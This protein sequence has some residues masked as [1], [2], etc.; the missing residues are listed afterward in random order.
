[1]KVAIVSVFPPYRGGIARFNRHLY[2]TLLAEQHQVLAINFKR[3]YPGFIFPGKTQFTDESPD[4]DIEPIMDTLSMRSWWRTAARLNDSDVETVIIPFWTS[5]L[6]VAKIGLIKKLN[7]KR[8]I[9]LV[10]N[11]VPHDAK[12]WQKLL[13]RRFFN[14]CDAYI[15]LSGSVTHDLL[16]LCPRVN[17]SQVIELFHPVYPSERSALSRE[18]ACRKL[19]LDPTKKTLLYFGLI[20]PYKGVELI[21]DAMNH[22]GD[23]YQLLIAGEPYYSLDELISASARQGE[24]IKWHTRFIPDEDVADYFRAAD[25]LVLPYRDATQSGVTAVGIYHGVPALVSNVGGLSEYVSDGE[26]GVLF[27]PNDAEALA[28]GV[29]RWFATKGSPAQVSDAI[30][31]KAKALSW[32]TFVNELDSHLND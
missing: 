27:A 25:A 3:Q 12:L 8:V 31:A 32:Q 20:R 4:P 19:G 23:A 16:N 6:A 15:T 26:T 1:M 5:Y 7:K 30:A 13:A 10:H 11:A 22:L 17:A 18:E 21:V 28:K 24:R 9:A 29:Q 14:A 2:D